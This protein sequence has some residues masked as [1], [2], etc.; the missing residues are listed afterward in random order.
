M[1]LPPCTQP[2]PS[3][4]VGTVGVPYSYTPPHSGDC[5]VDYFGSWS[6]NIPPGLTPATDGSGTLSGTPT[7]S[8]TFTCNIRCAAGYFGYPCT[9]QST[10]P[11]L[12]PI[13]IK[14]FAAPCAG[15]SLYAWYTGSGPDADTS[16]NFT[17][18]PGINKIFVEAVGAGNIEGGNSSGGGGGGYANAWMDVVPGENFSWEI[19]DISTT[20]GDPNTNLGIYAR[21]GDGSLGGTDNRGQVTNPGQDGEAWGGWPPGDGGNGGASGSGGLG[22]LGS[23]SMS[24]D[25]GPG[26]DFGGGG[27]GGWNNGEVGSNG[28]V[29]GRGLVAIYVCNTFGYNNNSHRFHDTGQTNNPIPHDQPLNQWTTTTSIGLKRQSILSTALA[30]TIPTPPLSIYGCYTSTLVYG[31]ALEDFSTNVENTTFLLNDITNPN[32]IQPHDLLLVTLCHIGNYVPTLSITTNTGYWKGTFKQAA[33]GGANDHDVYIET[34]YLDNAYGIIGLNDYLTL[35]FDSGSGPGQTQFIYRIV[36][37]TGQIAWFQDIGSGSF[38]QGPSELIADTANSNTNIVPREFYYAALNV[39]HCNTLMYPWGGGF[40]NGVEQLTPT[41]SQNTSLNDGFRVVVNPQVY[42]ATKPID[43]NDFG[44]EWG[45]TLSSYYCNPYPSCRFN[46]GYSFVA[47]TTG[48]FAIPRGIYSIFV[49]C[50]GSGADGN[51]DGTGG[52]GGG[53]A[54]GFVYVT[55]GQVVSYTIDG[56]GSYVGSISAAAGNGILGGTINVGEYVVSGG[57]GSPPI[58]REDICVGCYDGGDG[59]AGVIGA[60]GAGGAASTGNGGAGNAIGG[61]GGGAGGNTGESG[62]GG[63]GSPGLIRISLCAIRFGWRGG[64]GGGPGGGSIGGS[65]HR[66]HNTGPTNDPI[67]HNVPINQYTSGIGIGLRR[68]SI[69]A[70]AMLT[71]PPPPPNF[72]PF[73]NS[74]FQQLIIYD[75]L[76]TDISDS[77]TVPPGMRRMIAKVWARGGKGEDGGGGNGGWGAGGGGYAGSVFRVVPGEIIGY[78]INGGSSN[79]IGLYGSA[80]ANAGA[81]EGG[82][83]GGTAFGDVA[84]TGQD[85]NVAGEGAGGDGGDG[86]TGGA[87]GEG[88]FTDNI[89]GRDGGYYGGGGGGGFSGGISGDM[90]GGLPGPGLIVMQ[91]CPGFGFR[92]NTHRVH[93]TGPTSGPIPHNVPLNQWSTT[94]GIGFRRKPLLAALSSSTT[95]PPPPPQPSCYRTGTL[96]VYGVEGDTVLQNF[97]VPDGVYSIF[98]ECLGHGGTGENTAGG[99]TLYVGQGGGAGAYAASTIAVTP[100]DSFTITVN[101]GGSA[102]IVGSPGTVSAEAAT[103]ITGG[104]A[105]G[106]TGDITISGQ[107]GYLGESLFTD[108]ANGNGGQGGN[109]QFGVGGLGGLGYAI[110]GPATGGNGQPGT[111]YGSGG[112]AGGYGGS[113]GG[114]GDIGA[115]GLARVTWCWGYAYG[116]PTPPHQQHDTGPTNDPITHDTPINDYTTTK[117]IG[118][119]R[120]WVL[121]AA[122]SASYDPIPVPL[123]PICGV[124]NEI[125]SFNGTLRN[126]TSLSYDGDGTFTVPDG[127][128]QI[129]VE[130]IGGGGGG[131]NGNSAEDEDGGGGGG[132][133]AYAASLLSVV[134]GTIIS[135]NVGVGG[136]TEGFDGGTTSFDSPPTVSADYGRYG[137]GAIG[138]QGGLAVNCIG[139][140]AISGADGFT[141]ISASFPPVGGASGGAAGGGGQGGSGGNFNTG[142]LPGEYPGGGGGGSGSQGGASA[143]GADGL[144]RITYVSYNYGLTENPNRY[145]TVRH[146][147]HTTGQTNWSIPHC[148]PLNQ[149]TTTKGVSVRNKPLASALAG[150]YPP[151]PYPLPSPQPCAVPDLDLAFNLRQRFNSTTFYSNE[152][153]ESFDWVAPYGVTEIILQVQGS[154]TGGAQGGDDAGGC[155]GAGGLCTYYIATVVPGQSYP[156]VIDPLTGDMDFNNGDIVITGNIAPTGGPTCSLFFGDPGGPPECTAG[157]YGYG[158]AGGPD[159]GEPGE[160]GFGGGGGGGGGPG[161]PGGYGSVGWMRIFYVNQYGY[162]G[163]G[164][165]NGISNHY[166]S[167][168][169]QT[170]QTGQTNFSIS[171]CVPLNQQTT[172]KGISVRNKVFFAI[173]PPN[174]SPPVPPSPPFCGRMTTFTLDG[175]G[176]TNFEVPAGVTLIYVECIGGGANGANATNL[177]GEG[178]GGG[179]YGASLIAVNPGD[180]YT[181]VAGNIAQD[182]NFGGTTVQGIGATGQ[183]GGT[184]NVGNFTQDGQDGANGGISLGSGGN[185]GGSGSGASGGAGGAPSANGSP[186]SNFGGG[187]GGAGGTNTSATGGAGAVGQVRITWQSDYGY[188]GDF[189]QR[190]DTGQTNYAL[191]HCTPIN[192]WTTTKGIG[193][194]RKYIL[195]AAALEPPFEPCVR[196]FGESG[197]FHQTHSTGQ[198]NTA[199]SHYCGLN[200][201]TTTKGIGMRRKWFAAFEPPPPPEPPVPFTAPLYTKYTYYAAALI[202]GESVPSVPPSPPFCGRQVQATFTETTSWAVPAGV[203]EIYV[204]CVS[205][206]GGGGD[207]NSSG[208][209]GGGGGGASAYAASLLNVT[210]ATN[211]TLQIGV[212]GSGDG[213]N[214]TATDFNSG[215]VLADFGVGATG[216]VG[217]TGGLATN[218]V[219]DVTFDGID[220]SSGGGTG[221]VGGS[222]GGGG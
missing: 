10:T 47:T 201:W 76:V 108:P 102:D 160:N 105:G 154:G 15:K 164:N 198:T 161:A 115:P 29:G 175:P 30:A 159:Y 73:C 124:T 54:A 46:A 25:G 118:M 189:H 61:G 208:E 181:I 56:S 85:G 42:N 5:G 66:S 171:H 203:T 89:P 31:T 14:I 135:F 79:V 58:P 37:G 214:G 62:T 216:S 41:F 217:G 215:Q 184:G 167:R 94:T 27:G 23:L 150:P 176:S 127:I 43:E 222:G 146:Q 186:G 112:G 4:P 218:S 114:N 98:A 101:N 144:V 83:A 24:F 21:A 80:D 151:N 139:D 100:G 36:R 67:P 75:P 13:T 44:P 77:I 192:D 99:D 71:P 137:T 84:I 74:A 86:A 87:G 72:G 107:D 39:F 206:G 178:G 172:T 116:P 180:T 191:L 55:P 170:H 33:A 200:D 121:S 145:P 1:V 18:P 158:G 19:A 119:R 156:I 195:A 196:N 141:G 88:G 142:G 140:V 148:Q 194:R 173:D 81:G 26:Y 207:G 28:G 126:I 209:D 49:E 165:G 11:T 59:G 220:G 188:L 120:K 133:A 63:A 197:D 104:T 109:S 17:V 12:T 97:T 199:I 136:V 57:N 162:Y 106:S 65:P 91:F 22:G 185:G 51:V 152:N 193:M 111:F 132:G 143:A 149:F 130:C 50:W 35:T 174:P 68:K 131:G 16:G 60:G 52:G 2:S 103:G 221:A 32:T 157:G 213:A 123:P 190:H 95:P 48:G 169:H 38:G 128:T 147:T 7:A 90:V 70:G 202:A 53:F 212:G 183:S 125:L 8:G 204:E 113:S 40:L 166:P 117:G 9:G 129:Y 187:G 134:P 78:S 92:R 110:T 163:A 155:G 3:Y 182:S 64:G 20:F 153:L 122:L 6:P 205:G 211:Y 45:T 93:N 219:G 69:L 177:S 138:G 179:G 82:T 168:R 96:T 34:W 210:P